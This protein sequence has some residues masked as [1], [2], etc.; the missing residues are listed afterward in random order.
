MADFDMRRSLGNIEGK[1]DLMRS[2]QVRLIDKVDAI[3]TGGCAIGGA[4]ATRIDKLESAP[5]K[6]LF[7]G[8]AAGSTVGAGAIWG[9]IEAL[10][11]LA[12]GGAGSGA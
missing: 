4:N 12:G 7:G 1:M 5:R 10:K 9:A 3:Q 11:A 8:V 6:Q 2:E